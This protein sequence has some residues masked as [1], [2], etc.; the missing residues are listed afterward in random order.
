MISL[1]SGR[2]TFVQ[3]CLWQH[4]LLLELFQF[5]RSPQRSTGVLKDFLG[6]NSALVWRLSLSG[7]LPFT[8]VLWYWEMFI[9]CGKVF[10]IKTLSLSEIVLQSNVFGTVMVFP[11]HGENYLRSCE[12]LHTEILSMWRDHH[13]STHSVQ[14]YSSK[15]EMWIMHP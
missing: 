4:G 14:L 12:S 13:S 5:S 1:P 2:K 8:T 15:L 7:P 3:R 9:S 10:V 11:W 6:A